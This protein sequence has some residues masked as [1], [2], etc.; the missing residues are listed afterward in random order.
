MFLNHTLVD[1]NIKVRYSLIV[2]Y[3]VQNGLG[4]QVYLF[5]VKVCS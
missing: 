5:E 2:I 3:Y 1:D 4:K